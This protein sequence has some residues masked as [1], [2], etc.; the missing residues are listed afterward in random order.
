MSFDVIVSQALKISPWFIQGIF[1]V[2]L[3]PQVIKNFNQKSV[4]GLSSLMLFGYFNGYLATT[5]YSYCLDLPLAYKVITPLS[6]ATVSIMLGQHFFYDGKF[7]SMI[8]Y[9]ISI[10]IAISFIPIA[11]KH[12]NFVGNLF[13]WTSMTIW[14]TYQIPQVAKIYSTRSVVGFSFF[15][16]LVNGLGNLSEVVLSSLLGLPIQSVLS[17]IRGMMISSIFMMQ[18]FLYSKA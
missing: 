14:M 13:G 16:I 12:T 6:L 1:W 17:G 15:L 7:N 10:L 5:Y 8:Y 9:L 11:I 3:V 18:F 2:G 4:N